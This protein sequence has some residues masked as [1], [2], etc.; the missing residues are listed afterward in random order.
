MGLVR[1]RLQRGFALVALRVDA[2]QFIR[3]AL[4]GLVSPL[5][6]G[7]LQ[8]LHLRFDGLLALVQGIHRSLLSL[9]RLAQHPRRTTVGIQRG[10]VGLHQCD[11]PSPALFRTDRLRLLCQ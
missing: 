4:I 5:V 3:Q 1:D 10:I 6:I 2:L 9:G 11:S 7:Q 8:R